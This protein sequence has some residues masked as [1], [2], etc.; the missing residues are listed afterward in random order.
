[1]NPIL[2]SGVPS[3]INEPSTINSERAEFCP[4]EVSSE[5]GEKTTWVPGSIVRVRCWGTVTSPVISTVPLHVSFSVSVPEVVAENPRI[6]KTNK[7]NRIPDVTKEINVFFLF[8]IMSFPV[9]IGFILSIQYLVSSIF[10]PCCCFCRVHNF[11]LP[12]C[13]RIWGGWQA[14]GWSEDPDRRLIRL[15]DRIPCACSAREIVP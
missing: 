7:T 5:S 8:T 11:Q 3:A 14:S 1:M 13:A 2:L 15:S 4:P 6:G 12:W 10:I 9:F